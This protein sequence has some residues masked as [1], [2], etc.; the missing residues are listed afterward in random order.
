[1][2]NW[3]K[4]NYQRSL[5]SSRRSL[6]FRKSNLSISVYNSFILSILFNFV[7]YFCLIFILFFLCIQNPFRNLSPHLCQSEI[8]VECETLVCSKRGE[9][10]LVRFLYQHLTDTN[11][12]CIKDFNSCAFFCHWTSTMVQ[13]SDIIGNHSIGCRPGKTISTNQNFPDFT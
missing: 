7:I 2:G 3:V 13:V 9:V 8:K 10:R 1:M 4:F 12:T 6:I 5:L 11:K